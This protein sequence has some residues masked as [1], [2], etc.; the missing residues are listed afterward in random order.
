M[1]PDEFIRKWRASALTERS[2]A[3]QHFLDLCD[4]LGEPKPADVDPSGESY[5]FERGA[6]KDAGG[7][8]WGGDE[9]VSADAAR[10]ALALDHPVYDCVH[11]AL[12]HRVGATMLTADHR[13]AAAVAPTEHGDS[14]LTLADY[15]A[16]R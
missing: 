11:L 6:R 1:T 8:G 5:C 9:V 13:F 2:A 14:V 12:A 15:A 10:L 16:T 4:L 3:Q 7:E